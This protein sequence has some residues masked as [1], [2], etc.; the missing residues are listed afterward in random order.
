MEVLGLIKIISYFLFSLLLSSSKQGTK[1]I[2]VLHLS[3]DDVKLEDFSLT[4]EDLR[5]LR[6]LR[7]LSLGKLSLL[8]D[9]EHLFSKLR[10]LSWNCV[11]SRFKA[12]NLNLEQLAVLD[13]SRSCVSDLWEGWSQIKVRT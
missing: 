8:G 6:N 10:W 4:C 9:F 13:L 3:G 2:E 12:T 11:D 5:N 1:K 7:Y